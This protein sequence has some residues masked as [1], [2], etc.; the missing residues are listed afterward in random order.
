MDLASAGSFSILEAAEYALELAREQQAFLNRSRI[1]LVT[2]QTWMDMNAES[3]SYLIR[4]RVERWLSVAA[5]PGDEILNGPEMAWFLWDD[6]GID[7]LMQKYEPDLYEDFQRLP[8][9]V[10]KADVFRVVVLKRFGGIVSVLT[11]L[12]SIVRPNFDAVR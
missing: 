10:E 8:Y 6:D 7:A 3:W 9:P 5:Q 4:E 2:H 12:G 11:A 1:P